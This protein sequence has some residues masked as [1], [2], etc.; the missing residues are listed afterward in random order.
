MQSKDNCIYSFLPE[1][2]NGYSSMNSLA[3]Q[4]VGVE[5]HKSD[6]FDFDTGVKI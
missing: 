2:M 5:D 1:Q 3:S 6:M 4:S